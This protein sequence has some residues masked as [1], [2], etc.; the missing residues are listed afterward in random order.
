MGSIPGRACCVL[1][2]VGV[3]NGKST[4]GDVCGDVVNYQM[5]SCSVQ[6]HYASLFLEYILRFAIDK[7][8]QLT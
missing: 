7:V 4:W 8:N 2:V 5:A 3:I 1:W 6:E